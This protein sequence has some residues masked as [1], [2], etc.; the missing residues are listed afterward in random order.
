VRIRSELDLSAFRRA[1]QTLVERHAA[2]RTTF[3]AVQGKPVQ[4]VHD[5]AEVCFREIDAARWSETNIDEELLAE[6]HRPFDLEHGP[7]LRIFVFRRSLREHVVL[8]TVHH[9]VTDFWS[10]AVLVR[11]LGILY[12]AYLA[13]EPVS[14]PLLPLRYTDY[15]RWHSNL[16]LT[17]AG[18]R[19]RSYWQ[20]QLAGELPVLSAGSSIRR[21]LT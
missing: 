11:E 17:P 10:L 1:F 9:I 20:K 6:A 21:A 5:Q 3:T 15:V 13:N 12:A 19:L 8:L 16:L 4:H 2:L 18:E 7:L 14:L